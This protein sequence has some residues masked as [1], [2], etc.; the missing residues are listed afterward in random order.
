MNETKQTILI[1]APYGYSI[2]NLLFSSFWQ[3]E[4]IKK[5]N[6]YILTPIPDTYTRYIQEHGLSNVEVLQSSVPKFSIAFNLLWQIYKTRFLDRTNSSTQKIRW[7]VLRE[8]SQLAF[9][10]KKFV[11]LVSLVF[12]ENFL[13]KVII[14][15]SPKISPK[16]PQIDYWL[17]LA[18]SFEVDVPILKFLEVNN[19]KLK[20]IAF[21][22]S[23][24]NISSKGSLITKF[25]KVAVWG[26]IMRKEILE[27]FDYKDSGVCSVV[28]PQYDLISKIKK[29]EIG[30]KYSSRYILYA[31]GHPE[32]IPNEIE[33][34]K[35]V[36]SSID[37]DVLL[38]L[39]VHPN[40]SVEK[41]QS[42]K[43]KFPNIVIE[44]P[45]ER[46]N[47]TYDRWSPQEGDIIHMVSLLKNAM[48]VI[49]IA[50]TMALDASYFGTPVICLDYDK[51]STLDKSIKRFYKYDHYRRLLKHGGLYLC[52]NAEELPVLIQKIQKEHVLSAEQQEM[53][54]QY[55]S[56]QDCLAGK[57]LGDLLDE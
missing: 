25:D 16:L 56:F 36:L 33:Y 22:H 6:V 24:D 54:K 7:Q 14:F 26:D 8:Q 50:S 47:K 15:L 38:V 4:K 55:D 28:M 53:I 40:D 21:I 46:N 17:S 3:S 12:P 49:N 45:G 34:V 39:R 13:Q 19:P 20:K 35:D 57:R 29:I 37:K 32:T 52:E 9:C 18:P 5:S 2:K 44:E 27:K 42:L 43:K 51:F 30:S 31:T 1:T 11:I 10:F 23:W 41:Y 48:V